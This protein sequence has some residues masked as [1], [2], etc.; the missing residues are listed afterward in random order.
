MSTLSLDRE[1]KLR[2][3]LPTYLMLLHKR[4]TDETN[5]KPKNPK[6]NLTKNL[7]LHLPWAL[8][9][10]THD[11]INMIMVVNRS[12]HTD[13][14]FQSAPRLSEEPWNS[15]TV[16]IGQDSYLRTRAFTFEE[17]YH[18]FEGRRNTFQ[19]PHNQAK[20]ESM[21]NRETAV[22]AARGG[23]CVL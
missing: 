22:L 12:Y 21:P 17:T 4:H 6:L 20:I 2:G 18:W 7:L 1:L 11:H 9:G 15:Y 5:N 23:S 14:R 16:E 8:D 3:E 13:A 19:V 10:E